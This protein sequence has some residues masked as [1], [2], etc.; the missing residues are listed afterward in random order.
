MKGKGKLPQYAVPLI[1]LILFAR[2]MLFGGLRLF[3]SE[4]RNTQTYALV[5]IKYL[6]LVQDIRPAVT[7][8]SNNWRNYGNANYKSSA[9]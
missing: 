5:I 1:V 4:G 2:A 6:G 3:I 8:T 7:C 9:L